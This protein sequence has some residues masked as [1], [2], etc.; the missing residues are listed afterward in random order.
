MPSTTY[1]ATSSTTI[2][3]SS[4]AAAAAAPTCASSRAAI[5]EAPRDDVDDG[6]EQDNCAICLDRDDTAAAEWKETP[7]G[8]RF[9]GG[10]LDK[11]LEAAH[12]TC[13]MSTAVV[14]Q[15]V[16]PVLLRTLCNGLKPLGYIKISEATREASAPNLAPPMYS[17]GGHLHPFPRQATAVKAARGW[18]D[19]ATQ[20]PNLAYLQRGAGVSPA[21]EAGSPIALVATAGCGGE[22]T[23]MDDRI[24]PH[25]V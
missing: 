18:S 4:A 11:W 10:C 23:E 25:K 1:S 12:A 19:L 17:T 15:P 20:G 2:P 5:V 24:W 9:H 3:S 21:G 16:T 13:P 8:H 14:V 22:G 7:S 6:Q